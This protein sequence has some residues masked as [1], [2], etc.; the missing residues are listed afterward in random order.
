M[1]RPAVLIAL[2][3]LAVPATAHAKQLVRYELTGGFA[4]RSDR[5]VIDRDGSA[6]QTG[7][8]RSGSQHFTVPAKQLRAL[9]RELKA[10]R[11]RSLKRRYQ[12]QFPVLD[13]I[14]QTATYKGRSVSVYSGAKVPVRLRR[15]LSRLSRL[16]RV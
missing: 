2:L 13:G 15:V 14:T 8:R 10:A 1:R 3:V 11:F 12:P 7:S 5:L 4:P 16:M 9:K 6:W